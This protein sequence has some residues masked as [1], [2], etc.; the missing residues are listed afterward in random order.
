MGFRIRPAARPTHVK[1]FISGMLSGTMKVRF[2]FR[3]PYS[4]AG[5]ITRS[6]M[7]TGCI[8]RSVMA[9]GYITRERDGYV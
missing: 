3:N 4:P 1:R 8:T 9:T 7:A 6:V 5:C 2:I